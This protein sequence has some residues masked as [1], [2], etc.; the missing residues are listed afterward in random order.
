MG[1]PK[2][3]LGEAG[4]R[5]TSVTALVLK[6]HICCG[7]SLRYV[8]TEMTNILVTGQPVVHLVKKP[9][10]EKGIKWPRLRCLCLECAAQT[11]LPNQAT[12]GWCSFAKNS[13]ILALGQREHG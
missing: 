1:D 13:G 11:L 6:W 5:A 10:G 4:G 7:G 9:S 2:R 12:I 3:T 8:D